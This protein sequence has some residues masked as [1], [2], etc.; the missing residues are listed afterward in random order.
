MK[1]G[2]SLPQI[3]KL[4][5]AE[6]IRSVAERAVVHLRAG[7]VDLDPHT[8]SQLLAEIDSFLHRRSI[9]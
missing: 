5:S 6:A 3:G 2:L 7:T 1:F 9:L 4:A 8:Q